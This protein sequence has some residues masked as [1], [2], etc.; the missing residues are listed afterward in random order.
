MHPAMS[1]IHYGQSIF[2]G[3]K[4][5]KTVNDEVV[6]FRPDVHIAKIK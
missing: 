6:I 3:L 1:V 2:E 5:F 4:A